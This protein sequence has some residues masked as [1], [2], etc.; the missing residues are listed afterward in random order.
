[1]GSIIR[2][3]IDESFILFG[4]GT[5]DLVG[6][7]REIRETI[8][9]WI[10]ISVC[11]GIGTSKTVAKA[12]NKLAKKNPRFAGVLNLTGHPEQ[13]ELLEGFPVEDVWGIGRRRAELLKGQGVT[14]ARALRDLDV[15]WARANLSVAG[16]RTVYELRGLSCIPIEHSPPPRKMMCSSRTFGGSVMNL[17]ELK[18]AAAHH[19][20]KIGEKLRKQGRQ[21][22]A[23]MVFFK[24]SRFNQN[25]PQH[26]GYGTIA[27]GR[28]TA[29]TP[30]LVEAAG[31]IIER[32]FRIGFKYK[33]LGLIALDLVPISPEQANLFIPTV[34]IRERKAMEA[35]DRINS[36]FGKGTLRT[37]A[38]M[39]LNAAQQKM[40]TSIPQ[41]HM[42][43]THRTSRWTT[44]WDEL[45]QAKA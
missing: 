36:R 29:H 18:Q 7:G 19:A 14:T 40:N 32:E 5:V 9:K 3:S 41:W 34:G 27:F 25:E 22:L 6:I 1:M 28:A 39:D 26:T 13:E 33:K 30:E 23:L 43:Q 2:Y 21:T 15:A 4:P 42:K 12:A 37:A 8:R 16:Q 45:P 44:R 38:E 17:F 20:T 10:G 35:I 11:I 31:A 24:T